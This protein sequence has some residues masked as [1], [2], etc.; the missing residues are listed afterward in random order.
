MNINRMDNCNYSN[1]LSFKEKTLLVGEIKSVQRAANE[2]KRVCRRFDIPCL[3]SGEIPTDVPNSG[4]HITKD[5]SRH[6]IWMDQDAQEAMLKYPK[7]LPDNYLLE[8]TPSDSTVDAETFLTA[9]RA[10]AHRS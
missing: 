6:I 8:N 5:G 9:L 7:G 1:Q 2:M 10:Y 4:R 3:T